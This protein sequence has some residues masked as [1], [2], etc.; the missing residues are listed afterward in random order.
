MD[1][2]AHLGFSGFLSAHEAAAGQVREGELI[3]HPIHR[4][5]PIARHLLYLQARGVGWGHI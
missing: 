4:N 3:V 2:V 5:L 1:E